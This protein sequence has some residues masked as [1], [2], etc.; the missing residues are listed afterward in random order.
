MPKPHKGEEKD[1]FVS[2]CIPIVLKDGTATT[3]EQAVAVC[4]SIWEQDKK[5]DNK[6]K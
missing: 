5:T 1:R 3:Q 2:R 4:I 6:D